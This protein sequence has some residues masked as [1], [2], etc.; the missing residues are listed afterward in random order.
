MTEIFFVRHGQTAANSAKRFQGHSDTDLD[1]VGRRQALR[2]ADRL[3][4]ENIAAI[5]TS[6]LARAR[7]TAEPLAALLGIHLEARADLREIDVGEAVG[8]TKDEL[9]QR[10]PAIFTDG[11]QRVAFPGG[12]S[13]EQ[14]A[15]RVSRAAREIAAAARGERRVVAVTHGGA[16]RAA[17]A[18]LA[19]IPI[20][21]LGGLFVRN[22]SI[23]RIVVDEHG[24]GRLLTLNDA[25]H[26]EAW[27]TNGR[28]E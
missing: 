17:I 22:T 14:T 3:A 27:A 5:Y 25:A 23:T 19:G 1:E 20:E 10:H 4:T 6:D 15:A 11:W 13:Y 26:L 21:A 24:R 16:I 18:G 28:R 7:Q 2:L 8:L 12:E 9:R